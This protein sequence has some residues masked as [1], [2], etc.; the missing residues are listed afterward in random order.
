MF[1]IN[2]SA[3]PDFE[4]P[5]SVVILVYNI[6]DPVITITISPHSRKISFKRLAD[7][8]RVFGKVIGHTIKNLSS[9]RLVGLFK[10]IQGIFVPDCTIGQEPLLPPRKNNT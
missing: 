6:Y 4:Y 9:R 7:L 5:D 3:V 8:F 1:F 2:L 10:V